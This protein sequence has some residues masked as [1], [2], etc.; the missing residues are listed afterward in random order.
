ML[1]RGLFRRRPIKCLQK[2]TNF[3]FFFIKSWKFWIP[4][5]SFHVYSDLIY[6]MINRRHI[7]KILLCNVVVSHLIIHCP[8][9][10]NFTLILCYISPTLETLVA[11][12]PKR[13][14]RVLS[15]HIAYLSKILQS[16]GLMVSKKTL[17]VH[18][19]DMA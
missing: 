1:L 7:S 12:Y 17:S 6:S 10:S 11:S 15:A 19:R 3:L 18:D 14:N 2:K 13:F 5:Y 4:P 8:K 9:I 16:L